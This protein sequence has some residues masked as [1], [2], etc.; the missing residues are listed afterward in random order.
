MN[1]RLSFTYFVALHQCVRIMLLESDFQDAYHR[2]VV[3]FFPLFESARRN[4]F[5]YKIEELHRFGRQL[6][7][8]DEQDHLTTSC[9]SLSITYQLLLLTCGV[10]ADV[11]IGYK[12][13][14]EKLFS[15]AWVELENE[16][17]LDPQNELGELV[18]LH[19]LTLQDEI[20][21]WVKRQDESMDGNVEKKHCSYTPSPR[22]N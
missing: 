7:E 17:K 12:K 11:V 4:P 20:E 22:K 5:A 8:L 3:N 15:H 2:L 1:H 19:R 6:Y 13:V 18:E 9:V 10:K 21:K 16:R 14:D